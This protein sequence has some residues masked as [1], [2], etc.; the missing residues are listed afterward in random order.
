[1]ADYRIPKS[2]R[3]GF[4]E[5]CVH[6]MSRVEMNLDDGDSH[7]LDYRRFLGKCSKC[8]ISYTKTLDVEDVPTF[9]IHLKRTV[10]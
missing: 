1:M 5:L 3:N 8:G 7:D 6:C 4:V 2:L 10:Q 9:D